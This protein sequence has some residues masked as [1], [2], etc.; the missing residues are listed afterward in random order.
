MFAEVESEQVAPFLH[1]DDSHSFLSVWQL[2]PV[3]PI[4]HVHVYTPNGTR[5]VTGCT[6]DEESVHTALFMHG[7]DAHSFVSYSHEAPTN[8]IGHRHVC[9]STPAVH[10]APFMHGDDEHSSTSWSQL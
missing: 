9:T 6:R 3:K 1:G 10:V 8:P 5:P 7:I 4:M 2:K